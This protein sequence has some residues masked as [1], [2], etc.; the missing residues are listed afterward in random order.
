MNA[1]LAQ[2]PQDRWMGEGTLESPVNLALTVTPMAD[3]SADAQLTS[4]K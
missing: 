4:Y 3:E 1:W 2:V